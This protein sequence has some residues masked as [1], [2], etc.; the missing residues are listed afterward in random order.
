M[1]MIVALQYNIRTGAELFGVAFGFLVANINT[2]R[3]YGGN[4]GVY[5]AGC[6]ATGLD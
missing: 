5:K 2:G 4:I 6:L 1:N 3:G